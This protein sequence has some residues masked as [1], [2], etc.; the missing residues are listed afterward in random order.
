[1]KSVSEGD[2]KPG[3][4]TTNYTEIFKISFLKKKKKKSFV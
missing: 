4:K 2:F 1:M 3:K